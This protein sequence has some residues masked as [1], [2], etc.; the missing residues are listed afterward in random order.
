MSDAP[1]VAGAREPLVPKLLVD[2]VTDPRDPGYEAAAARRGGEPS[3]RWWDRPAVALGC[4]IVGFTLA[5][6]YAHTNR[7]APETAKV[8][9]ALVNRV[10][11]AEA[12]GDSLAKSV[13]TLSGQ[14]N[15]VR[16]AALNGASSALAKSV[17]LD[18][19]EAGSIVVTGPGLTVTLKDPTASASVAPNGSR[20]NEIAGNQ[21]ITDRDVRSVV[22]ELWADGAEAIA[23]NGIRLTPTSA[24][25]FAGDAVLV[26]YQPI[27]SPY[28]IDA[29]GNADN[30]ATGFAESDVASRYTTLAGVK[31]IGFSFD[32]HT[33]LTL[34]ASP[35]VSLRYARVYPK[36][37]STHSSSGAHK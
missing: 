12:E 2:L 20:A 8:H 32:E 4:V 7:S 15:S 31:G 5:V 36:T 14:L 23:V 29:I 18:Q 13:Q 6:A 24:I 11:S 1:T 27:S 3:N 35:T 10:R 9:T 17:N 34:P 28:T 22:N 37:P 21:V 26:D 30:L 25:R 33:N 19:L 16:D